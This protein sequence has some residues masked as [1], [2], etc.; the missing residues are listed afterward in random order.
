MTL[1]AGVSVSQWPDTTRMARGVSGPATAA[2][3]HDSKNFRA[4]IVSSME[5]VGEPCDRKKVSMAAALAWS[6]GVGGWLL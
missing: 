2:G 3:S 1:T 6:V 4:G 5:S